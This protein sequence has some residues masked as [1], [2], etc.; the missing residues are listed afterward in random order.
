MHT[1]SHRFAYHLKQGAEITGVLLLLGL[2]LHFILL[3]LNHYGLPQ[4]DEGSWLAVAAELAQGNGFTTR[5]LENHW[6]TP[7]QLPRPDDFRYPGLTLLLAWAFWPAGPSLGVAFGVITLLYYGFALSVFFLTRRLY[8]RYAA[9]GSLLLILFS[10]HQLHWNTRIYSEGL[11]G[12]VL[13]AVIA[14]SING[15]ES[16]RVWWML[17][18]AGVGLLYLVRPNALLFAPAIAWHFFR[19]RKS[20]SL[21]L[22]HLSFAF[23]A[24][25]VVMSP[26]LMRT[27]LHFGNPFHFAGNAGLLRASNDES[28]TLSML[29][30]LTRHGI[31]F[32]L[33]R[34][35]QG[36]GGF[37]KALDFYEHGR[38]ILPLLTVAGALFFR[39][40]F[41]SPFA[42]AGFLLTFLACVYVSYGS[43]AGARY[44]SSFLP[45]LFAYG[46]G[47]TFR[48]IRWAM[49]TPQLRL[50]AKRVGHA[51]ALFVLL[52]LA[53]SFYHPHRFFQKFYSDSSSW[54][55][56]IQEHLTIQKAL[57]HPR[58]TYY[59][60]QLCQVNFLTQA[61]CIGLNEFR[62][63]LWVE[64]SRKQFNPQYVMLTHTE[65]QDDEMQQAIARMEADG[66]KLDTLTTGKLAVYFRIRAL[67]RQ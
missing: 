9:W 57:L 21:P 36:I 62:D 2:G 39:R 65:I 13:V 50:H 8:G 64:R 6:L 29:E 5:W 3:R 11:F 46:L 33:Q 48:G 4:G 61:H 25:A 27:A 32:P 10:L 23:L 19:R 38:Q 22:S 54:R 15:G 55:S 41:Y 28:T 49:A 42:A 30:F 63:S 53:F 58:E 31:L 34:M 26:W 45:L 47:E 14:H 60:R 59:A 20:H 37:W 12:L 16:R 40:P 17:L 52:A 1:L 56:E 67:D 43:W 24:M 7:Y 35:V 44:F 51:A 18:G 66:L